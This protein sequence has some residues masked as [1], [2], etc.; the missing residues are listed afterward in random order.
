MNFW[1]VDD[2]IIDHKLLENAKYFML[3]KTQLL[4][5]PKLRLLFC[6]IDTKHKYTNPFL[7]PLKNDLPF[8]SIIEVESLTLVT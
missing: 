5:H 2:L 6:R 3:E 1:V 8:K 7:I 4:M